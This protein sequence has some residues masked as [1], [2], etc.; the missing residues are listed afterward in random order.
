MKDTLVLRALMMEDVD[1]EM[2]EKVEKEI[3]VRLHKHVHAYN[4]F[5]RLL[6]ALK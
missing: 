3:E 1:Q 2:R 4:E 5:Q 6:K